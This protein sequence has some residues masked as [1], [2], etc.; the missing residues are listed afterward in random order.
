MQMLSTTWNR[1]A[2]VLAR[3][4]ISGNFGTWA[5]RPKPNLVG[6]DTK[7][8]WYKKNHLRLAVKNL[9]SDSNYHNT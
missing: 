3:W 6:N 5:G 4:E 1:D 8:L 9:P 7:E 2:E